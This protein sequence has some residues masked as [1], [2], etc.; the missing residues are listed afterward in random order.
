MRKLTKIFTAVL[1]ALGVTAASAQTVQ[2]N[3]KEVSPAQT[4]APVKV[5]QAPAGGAAEGGAAGGAAAGGVSA[6]AIAAVAV[7]VALVA[8]AASGGSDSTPTHAP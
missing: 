4:R 8:A 1:C 6:G 7:G 2:R 5:A 3:G